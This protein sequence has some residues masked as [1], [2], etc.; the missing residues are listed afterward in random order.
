MSE[1]PTFNQIN[2]Q[3][4]TAYLELSGADPTMLI[5]RTDGRVTV[6]NYDTRTNSAYFE[7]NGPKAH[8][9][10]TPEE[11]S[12]QHQ[13]QLASELA[14]RALRGVEVQAPVPSVHT[15]VTA[16]ELV[17]AIGPHGAIGVDLV[18]VSMMPDDAPLTRRTISGEQFFEIGYG[19]RQDGT[20]VTIVYNP[21]TNET[22]LLNT[23]AMQE[24]DDK[25][26]AERA[27]SEIH[28]PA[29]TVTDTDTDTHGSV[30]YPR[31]DGFDGRNMPRPRIINL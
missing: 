15:E 31:S 20:K 10:M 6:A 2:R 14:G 28:K 26:V 13:E 5:R 27:S 25:R 17:E 30:E 24:A 22:S 12:D 3:N 23:A 9:N 8:E 18:D 7:E 29:V 11:L 19:K 21:G 16:G 1:K 4:E